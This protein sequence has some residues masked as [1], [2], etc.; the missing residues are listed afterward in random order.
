VYAGTRCIHSGLADAETAS[1]ARDLYYLDVVATDPRWDELGGKRM[2][3]DR[4]C[5]DHGRAR[6]N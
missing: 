4:D 2:L 1:W 5:I 3:G 6:G